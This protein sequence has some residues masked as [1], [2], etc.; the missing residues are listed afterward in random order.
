[1]SNVLLNLSSAC[2]NVDVTDVLLILIVVP[3]DIIIA[4]CEIVALINFSEILMDSR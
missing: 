3:S 1:M 4:E 2:N